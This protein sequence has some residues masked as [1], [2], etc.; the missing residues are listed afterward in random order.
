[1]ETAHTVSIPCE[2]QNGF[3]YTLCIAVHLPEI[4]CSD[5]RKQMI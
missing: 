5:K 4:I 3:S 1:M 2:K